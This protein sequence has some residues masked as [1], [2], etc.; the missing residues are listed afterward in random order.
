MDFKNVLKSLIELFQKNDIDFALIG[1]L[2]LHVYH[3][4][5]ATSDIDFL[6][7][8]EDKNKVKELLIQEGYIS[9]Y[10]TNNVM[11]MYN[12]NP[13]FGRVDFLFAQRKY[14]L[15]MLK[16]ATIKKLF[17]LDVKF[18]NVEDIIGLKVQS[19]SNDNSRYDQDM[20]DIKKLIKN[21]KENINMMLVKEYFDIFN[22]SSELEEVLKKIEINNVN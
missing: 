3:V 16:N 17:D 18:A 19:S 9:V 14:T 11:N 22:R 10:E 5:R 8:V 1:G 13:D 2:A 6:V 20:S 4:D 7:L 15:T 12:P 21:N